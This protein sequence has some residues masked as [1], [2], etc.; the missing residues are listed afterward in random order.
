MECSKKAY[1]LQPSGA[2]SHRKQADRPGGGRRRV[3]GGGRRGLTHHPVVFARGSVLFRVRV[4]PSQLCL[5]FP[6]LYRMSLP[7]YSVMLCVRIAAIRT[8]SYCSILRIW[9]DVR[10]GATIVCGG[11]RW[12]DAP[13]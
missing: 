13:Q 10:R 7:P 8:R 1:Q 9:A 3:R 12:W 6:W 11:E 5:A 4:A 2:R